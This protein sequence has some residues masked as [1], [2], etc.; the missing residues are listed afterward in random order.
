MKQS[1]QFWVDRGGT[2]TDVIGIDDKGQCVIEKL[3][4]EAPGQ[5]DDAVIEGIARILSAQQQTLSEV[6]Q[7]K[8]GTTV[9]T[10]ALLQRKGADCAL[11]ITSGFKDLLT[12][13]YQNRPDLFAIH[14]ERP[15]PLYGDVVEID[16]RISS[17]GDVLEAINEAQIKKVLAQLK[18]QNIE[19]LAIVLLHSVQNPVHEQTIANIA[20]NMGFVH[21]YCSHATSST[22]KAVRRGHTTVVD[23]Y[24]SPILRQYIDKGL[25]P[26]H[27][28][29]L[30]FMQS[31]GGLTKS[32]SF[33]GKNSIL[34]GPAGGV[35]GAIEVGKQLGYDKIIGFDMGGTSTDV[36]HYQGQLERLY[37]TEMAGLML[38]VPMLNIHTVAAGGGSILKYQDN[39]LVA[40]PESAGANPGPACYR[41]GGPLTITDATVVVGKIPP[42][43]FTQTFEKNQS[44]DVDSSLKLFKKLIQSDFPLQTP[45]QLAHQFIEIAVDNMSQAIKQIS[46]DK[47]FNL[48]GYSLVSFGGAGGQH[49]CLIAEKLG[50][51]RVIVPKLASVLSAYGIGCSALRQMESQSIEKPFD[52]LYEERIARLKQSL[53]TQVAK[54]V[55]KPGQPKFITRYFVK[56]R[57]SDHSIELNAGKLTLK[58]LTDQFHQAHHDQYGYSEKEKPVMLESINI[59]AIVEQEQQL[60]ITPSMTPYH[61][62]PHRF[63]SR[64]QWHEVEALDVVTCQGKTIS[65][66]ALLVGDNT[67]IIVEPGWQ[68]AVDENSNVIMSDISQGSS[69]PVKANVDQPSPMLLEIFNHAFINC[70]ILMGTILAQT[71]HSVNI[72]ERRD[73]SCALFDKSGR[74]IANAPHM[75]VHLGSMSE[76]VKSILHSQ[77]LEEGDS[78]LLNNPYKGGTHLPDIT[79]ITPYF[80]DGELLFFV[81]SRGHHADIGGITPGSLPA[82]S[83]TIDEEGV[84]I[85]AFLLVKQGCLQ[86]DALM[87]I[88]QQG[89]ARNPEQNIADIKAQ[90]AANRRGMQELTHLIETYGCELLLAY[91]DYTQDNAKTCVAN[92]LTKLNSGH[93]HYAMDGDMHIDVSFTIHNGKAVIDFQK[94][95]E[96][97]ANNFNAPTAVLK[98]SVLYVLRTLVDHE[99][100]LNEGCLDLVEIRLPQNSL[101]NPSYP[102]AVVAGNVETSQAIVNALYCALGLVA[103]S[104]GT[105]NNLT[106]GT[107]QFQYYETLAGGAGA[108]KTFSGCDAIHSHMTNSLLTDPE[109]LEARFPVRVLSFSIRP[110]SGG[111]GRY[112]GGN[113]I[114]RCLLFGEDMEVNMISNHRQTAPP[115]IAGGASGAVGKNTLVKKDGQKENLPGCFAIQVK[116]G[117]RMIIET[118]GGGGYGK[119]D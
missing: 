26:L 23:A 88:L 103:A 97:Q 62:H 34:S 48:T 27:H 12:I 96:Q 36:C 32:Q 58:A 24:L 65:G 3:L 38:D 75:P 15:L 84:I 37:E 54:M 29:D 94:T 79:V 110:D 111:K 4:S 52:H 77:T 90:L 72:K 106:F 87:K 74:L 92:V 82:H 6:S 55:D 8:M 89:G 115:G 116:S 104:Q 61:A 81:A 25:R 91:V 9:A 73:F 11:L 76:S 107:N 39:R 93:F 101:V 21:I 51:K 117:D 100:P 1:W 7:V 31:N 86:Q 40:G 114:Q 53:T 95:S 49:A 113:G 44:L 108:G 83:R 99:I 2:F 57:G 59:E 41:R 64:N 71:A 33:L 102:A 78:Y 35:V 85:D 43:S 18:Q 45:E 16:E 68:A 109:I 60:S 14:V 13:A 67:T 56:Y 119:P 10:N 42:D 70:A 5:Y 112:Q 80:H 46:I 105:M 47:G 50:M 69:K 28:S 30:Q 19:S 66:P 63:Y 118:P 20:E 98:A 17:N 22:P